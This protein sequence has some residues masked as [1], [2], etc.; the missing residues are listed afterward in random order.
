MGVERLI[1]VD[2]KTE[3]TLS[4]QK[5]AA[6]GQEALSNRTVYSSWSEFQKAE[7]EGVRIAFTARDGKGRQVRD[8]QET[9]QW[10]SNEHPLFT[11]EESSAV[12][13]Y[14]IFGP[15][16]WGLS[17]DDL[18][19]VH[20]ACSIPTFG[21]NTS[22]N[23]A[24]AVLLALYT[25]RITWGGQ[26]A[27]LEGQQPQRKE[28]DSRFPEKVLRSWIEEMGFDTSNRRINAFTVL[29]RML[30]QNVP[31]EKEMRILNT[32][33]NQGLRKLREYNQL[34]KQMGLPAIETKT[35]AITEEE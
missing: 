14:L 12:P 24:Q 6:T 9:L 10:L 22:L 21:D 32:V 33:L 27:R 18:E 16:D 17:G 19:Q 15:E 28:Q 25:L 26:K 7:T 34:R 30:L 29:R 8:F 20:F 2:P 5:A 4:A 3:I 13:V 11:A 35:E 23:L 1:L 31:S